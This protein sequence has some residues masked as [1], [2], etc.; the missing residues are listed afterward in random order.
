MTAVAAE[1]SPLGRISRAHQ[2]WN[3]STKILLPIALAVHDMAILAMMLLTRGLRHATFKL[4]ASGTLSALREFGFRI[5]LDGL[6]TGYSISSYM[7]QFEV[8][9][10]SST[11]AVEGVETED[12]EH[13]L[14]A[15]GCREMQGYLFSPA[16]SQGQVSDLLSSHT[17]WGCLACRI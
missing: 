17:H 1:P 14:S 12:Q 3:F 10:M 5:A 7:R 15:G 9:T 16:L 6:G 2:N 11:V 8:D 13:L 4:Q